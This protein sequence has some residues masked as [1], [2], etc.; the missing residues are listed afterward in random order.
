LLDLPEGLLIEVDEMD[1]AYVATIDHAEIQRCY[2]AY[3][4]AVASL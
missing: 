1:A 2:T 3:F 4:A